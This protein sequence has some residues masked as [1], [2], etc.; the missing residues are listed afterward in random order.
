M[1]HACLIRSVNRPCCAMYKHYTPHFTRNAVLTLYMHS[2]HHCRNGVKRYR[3]HYV[4]IWGFLLHRWWSVRFFGCVREHCNMDTSNT[5]PFCDIAIK[6][7]DFDNDVMKLFNELRPEW[8]K[9]DTISKGI[10]NKVHK[11]KHSNINV[12]AH[13]IHHDLDGWWL[14]KQRTSADFFFLFI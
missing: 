5:K 2:K 12:I 11:R 7:N 1:V 10:W 6:A 3:L 4:I 9:E 14:F 8:E 13:M